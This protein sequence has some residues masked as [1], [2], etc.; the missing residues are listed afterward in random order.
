MSELIKIFK[1]LLCQNLYLEDEI[2]YH[3][4][5]NHSVLKKIMVKANTLEKEG[6]S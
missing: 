2:I 5:K 6:I 3:L 4:E 1:C